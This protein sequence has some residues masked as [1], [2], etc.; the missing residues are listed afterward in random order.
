MTAQGLMEKVAGDLEFAIASFR[1]GGDG[2]EHIFIKRFMPI[3][4]L[5]VILVLSFSSSWMAH[6]LVRESS[7]DKTSLITLRVSGYATAH[8]IL[9]QCAALMHKK[10]PSFR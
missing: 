10:S 7:I 3:F 2:L 8:R 9:P 5:L 4:L 6:R 1:E